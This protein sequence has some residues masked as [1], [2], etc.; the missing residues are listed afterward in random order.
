MNS[1]WIKQLTFS[2]GLLFG[3]SQSEQLL[4]VKHEITLRISV[5]LFYHHLYTKYLNILECTHKEFPLL[6]FYTLVYRTR[7]E[8]YDLEFLKKEKQ[9]A[10]KKNNGC[11]K[12]SAAA[13]SYH[14]RTLNKSM[15]DTDR[16]ETT[17]N[18][19]QGRRPAVSGT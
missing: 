4:R 3:L 12:P 1:V 15:I 8:K 7:A 5:L 18:P 13:D 19:H 6:F 17:V 11:N 10:I 14:G 2:L 16:I 9:T